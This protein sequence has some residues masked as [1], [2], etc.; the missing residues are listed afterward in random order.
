MQISLRVF[1]RPSVRVNFTVNADF[2]SAAGGDLDVAG[3]GGDFELDGA[4]DGKRPVERAFG[5]AG[6]A[7]A[8]GSEHSSEQR[9]KHA[10]ARDCDADDA[11]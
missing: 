1:R 5:A 2:I 10:K 7:N 3:A 8:A 6:F 4:L 11:M 9:E